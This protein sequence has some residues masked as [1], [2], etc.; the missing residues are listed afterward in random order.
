LNVPPGTGIE[1][2]QPSAVVP[3]LAPAALRQLGYASHAPFVH[4]SGQAVRFH[5]PFSHEAAVV[6]VSHAT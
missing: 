5:V 1:V 6:E 2:Q 4:V 3:Q